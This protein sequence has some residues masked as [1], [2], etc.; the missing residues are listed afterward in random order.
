[1][2][3]AATQHARG[4][5]LENGVPAEG[6]GVPDEK[7]VDLTPSSATCWNSCLDGG[8]PPALPVGRGFVLWPAVPRSVPSGGMEDGECV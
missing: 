2:G 3:V 1:M 6:G 7:A 4:S 8:R 5:A